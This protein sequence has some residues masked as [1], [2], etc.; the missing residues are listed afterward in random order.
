MPTHTSTPTQ[1]KP[2]IMWLPA[3]VLTSTFVL[4]I[5]A[6]PWY[7]FTHG[8]SWGNWLAFALFLACNGLSITAGYHRLFAHNTY[9]AH[10]ALRLF[11]ALF[12]AAATQ[13]SI[14]VWASGH[15]RHH[16]HV[17][18]NDNDRPTSP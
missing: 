3:T 12:G 16:R 18:D 17:D 11:F 6:V 13:N 9:K 7:G 15:R 4:A 2:P 14:L 5:T 10:P 8:Y 1:P